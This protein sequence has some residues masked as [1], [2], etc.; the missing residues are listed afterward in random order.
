VAEGAAKQSRRPSG[1]QRKASARCTVA[2][3]EGFR[4]DGCDAYLF[5]IDGTLMHAQG[6]VHIDSFSSSVLEVLGRPVPLDNVLIHGNTDTGILRDAFAQA[7]IAREVW[8]PRLKEILDRM[9]AAVDARRE[10]M[11]VVLY[12]GVV[13]TLAYLKARGKVLG[14][15]TGNLE[16]IGWLKIDL[17][18]LRQWFSFGGF[19]DRHSARSEMIASAANEARRLV[20]PHAAVCVVG[21]TPS[22]IAAARANSLPVIAV[23]TGA[24]SFATLR[25]QEPEVTT[26][27]LAALLAYS[28]AGGSA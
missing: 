28:T 13:E 17:A 20:G 2:I 7:S 16:R 3:R 22:D 24:Y 10:Q 1:G 6:G 27:T 8:Q 5:D 25:E 4:W 14:V 9:C 11:K 19:S 23:A 12:P 18:G 21:D 15:A 26:S